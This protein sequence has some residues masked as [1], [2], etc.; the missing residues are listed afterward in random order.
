MS[1]MTATDALAEIAALEDPT[2]RAVNER[3]GDA[4]GVNLAKLRALAKRVG[5]DT[6]LA[7]ELWASDDV[8]GQLLGVLISKPRE[9]S[10]ADVDRMLRSTRSAKAHDWLVN[11]IA[12]KSPHAEALREQWFDDADADARAAAWSLTTARVVKKPEGLDLDALLDRIERELKDA[13]SREQ[14]AMNETLAQIGIQHPTYRERALEIGNRLQ[15]L[16]DYPTPPNCTSPFAPAWIA[17][18]VRRQG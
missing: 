7:R 5:M 6:D 1:T 13:P 18:M 10:V 16:A 9:L 4:H 15:V 3:H 2:A 12:K 17:E 14:W 11:Y 8:A